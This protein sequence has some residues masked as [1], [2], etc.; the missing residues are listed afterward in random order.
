MNKMFA[1]LSIC[2]V[3]FWPLFLF[4]LG[5]AVQI[6]RRQAV[7]NQMTSEMNGTTN[8]SKTELSNKPI[9][10]AGD[11]MRETGTPCKNRSLPGS[12]RATDGTFY[13]NT[14]MTATLIVPLFALLFFVLLFRPKPPLMKNTQ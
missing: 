7:H 1:R 4:D 5:H 6:D 9:P 3:A 12:E 13:I 8:A 11:K 14:A 2:I 10:C